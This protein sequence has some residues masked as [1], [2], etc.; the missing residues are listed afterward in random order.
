MPNEEL[1]IIFSSLFSQKQTVKQ[2]EY[3]GINENE[4]CSL[5]ESEG[6]FD[7]NELSS[8]DKEWVF[9]GASFDG[10]EVKN[11]ITRDESV[12]TS[13]SADFFIEKTSS[14]E[15]I[16]WCLDSLFRPEG[17]FWKI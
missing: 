17:K 16:R 6:L 3:G 7:F 11:P 10:N 8:V 13:C 2:S 15:N 12:K 5:L 14:G 1:I 9:D 4:T